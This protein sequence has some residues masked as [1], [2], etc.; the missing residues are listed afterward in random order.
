MPFNNIILFILQISKYYELFFQKIVK[1]N[2]K[3][4]VNPIFWS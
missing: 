4:L 3:H 2:P 1:K